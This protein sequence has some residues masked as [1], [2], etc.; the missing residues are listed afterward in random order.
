ME[1]GET[2]VEAA[3]RETIEETGYQVNVTDLIG[4]YTY[5]PPMFPDRT[6]FPFL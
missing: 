2:I 4:I 1:A 5:T 3:I 6:L